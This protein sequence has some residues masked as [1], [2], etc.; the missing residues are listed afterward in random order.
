MEYMQYGLIALGL[1]T[2]IIA[3][4]VHHRVKVS[5]RASLQPGGFF[6]R[7]LTACCHVPHLVQLTAQV[8]SRRVWE[9]TNKQIS[10]LR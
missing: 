4:I 8:W 7:L 1:A 6:K 3:A 10:H 9:K 2:I 5:L